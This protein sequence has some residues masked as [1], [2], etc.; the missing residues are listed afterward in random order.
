MDRNRKFI[1]C[2]FCVKDGEMM[3]IITTRTD[4]YLILKDGN[5]YRHETFDSAK[6]CVTFDSGNEIVCDSY[7][8]HWYHSLRND[9]EWGLVDRYEPIPPE[10]A[11]DD[12]EFLR[13]KGMLIY[14]YVQVYT[15]DKLFQYVQLDAECSIDFECYTDY[16][17]IMNSVDYD[18]QTDFNV[19]ELLSLTPFTNDK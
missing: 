3:R 15:R 4:Y 6:V 1:D 19:G 5:R 13:C 11:A 10:V 7:G 2:S 14:P 16:F 17:E 8:Q 12:Y 9:D 18:A